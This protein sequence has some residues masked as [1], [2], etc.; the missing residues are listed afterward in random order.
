[1]PLHPALRDL[2]TVWPVMYIPAVPLTPMN[3][4]YVRRQKERF[5]QGLPPPDFP[6]GKGE[7]EYAGV[8]RPE[9]I[10]SPVGKRAMGLAI[11]VA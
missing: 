8:G 6:P 2:L 9:D 7:A 11:E 3:A 5:V 4:D 1:M 10:E